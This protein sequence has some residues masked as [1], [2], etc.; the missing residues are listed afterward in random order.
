MTHLRLAGGAVL[1]LGL[2]ASV[3]AA[4]RFQAAPATATERPAAEAAS[5]PALA[6]SVIFIDAA[7]NRVAPTQEQLAELA[8][9]TKAKSIAP[10]EVVPADP[11]DPSKG[12][13]MGPRLH[14]SEARLGVD[15]KATVV[16]DDH[17][18]TSGGC[19]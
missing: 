19:K 17:N 3:T 10:A 8:A 12:V 11:K 1:V 7:G 16:C 18:T 15:G 13:M 2:I 4:V 5:A 9:Q 6:N 14:L